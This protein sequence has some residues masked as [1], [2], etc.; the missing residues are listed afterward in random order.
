MNWHKITQYS[1]V[2]Q[3]CVGVCMSF[4]LSYA[5]NLEENQASDNAIFS[6]RG[7]GQIQL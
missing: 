7:G 3:I 1:N 2:Y 4:M 5:D 6:V